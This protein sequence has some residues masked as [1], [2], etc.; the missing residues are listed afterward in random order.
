MFALKDF[1]ASRSRAA[2]VVLACSLAIG[3]C[4]DD[5]ST[6]P[7]GD[8]G[9]LTLRVLNR[10]TL[11]MPGTD[12]AVVTPVPGGLLVLGRITT[13]TPCYEL[14]PGTVQEPPGALTLFIIAREKAVG[15]CI[16]VLHA[17][18]YRLEVRELDPGEYD[19]EVIHTYPNTGWADR[20]AASVRV[21]VPGPG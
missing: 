11:S 5:T 8:S 9:P 19:V 14:S 6:G 21:V 7:D 16:Q 1:L 10:D 12:V 18:P 20:V 2:A 15:A 17:F 13:P 3:G 4:G